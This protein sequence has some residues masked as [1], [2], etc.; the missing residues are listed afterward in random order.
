MIQKLTNYW[1]EKT[2]T[3][4]LKSVMNEL[5]HFPTDNELIKIG[6]NDLRGA[7]SRNGGSNYLREKVGCNILRKSNGYWTEENII[8]ELKSVIDELGHFPSHSKLNEIDRCDLSAAMSK[9]GGSNYFRDKMGCELLKK[10]NGYWTEDTVISELKSVI[11]ELGHFPTQV[12]M[13]EI[14]KGN[15]AVAM[16]LH[17]GL[18]HFREKMGYDIFISWSEDRKSYGYWTEENIISEL[19]SVI[20]ELG[21]FPTGIELKKMSRYNLLKA[22]S[23]QGSYIHFMEKCGI[24]LSMQQKRRS[25]MASA[26]KQGI[27][28]DE[29]E[30]FA[31][32]QK[33]CPLFNKACKESVRE[34]YD[35]RCFICGLPE[36]ENIT[37]AG[38][39][40][41]LYVHHVDMDKQQGCDGKRWRLIPVC[42]QHHN[43]HNN[44]WMYRVIYLLGHVW[45]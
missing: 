18:N 35:R 40:K 11:N 3:S 4:E 20:D 42:I 26:A 24:T 2:T 22:M 25:I 39:L 27:P 1:T 13:K 33:Y 29:W 30:S 12:E 45:D 16:S 28:Y 5:G 31:T 37:S 23:K 38:K 15:L 41:K 34:K 7:I 44:L 9:N 6:R 19:K 14:G 36:S 43:L 21:H 10:P 32:E 17:G 8:F